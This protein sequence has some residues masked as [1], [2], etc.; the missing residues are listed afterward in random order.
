MSN[1]VKR[2]NYNSISLIKENQSINYIDLNDTNKLACIYG[3]NWFD[4]K[5]KKL[6]RSL[7]EFLIVGKS[8][9]LLGGLIGCSIGTIF[10]GYESFRQKSFWPFPLAIIGSG[11]IFANFFGI[12]NIMRSEVN[13]S[14]DLYYENLIFQEKKGIYEYRKIK[15]FNK[16]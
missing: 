1:N 4:K 10:G 15:F 2:N 14:E 11:I 6:K 3:F 7:N 12:I 8:G 16:E 9:F 5:S 13:N